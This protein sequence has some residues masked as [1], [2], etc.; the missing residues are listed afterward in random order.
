MNV[1]RKGINIVSK[2]LCCPLVPNHLLLSS[3]MA[4][5]IWKGFAEAMDQ[6]F[7]FLTIPHTIPHWWREAT[8][9]TLYNWL[10]VC[11]PPIIMWHLWKGRNKARFENVR[12][13]YDEIIKNIKVYA[14]DSYTI[15]KLCL[16]K[17]KCPDTIIYMLDL[18]YSMKKQ[19]TTFMVRWLPPW[20]L[21]VKLNTDGASRGNP[22]KAGCR[23]VIRGNR[24]YFTGAFCHCLGIKTC[25]FDEAYA[26]LEGL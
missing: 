3:E 9:N 5:A 16:E 19:S 15:N 26:V 6:P 7:S 20:N 2:C 17:G 4:A 23:G 13:D 11:L 22:G 25:M 8:C 21:W 14:H 10:L 24:G 12:M 1:R 18:K